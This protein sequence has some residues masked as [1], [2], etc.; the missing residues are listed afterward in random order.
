MDLPPPVVHTAECRALFVVHAVPASPQIWQ[1]PGQSLD[2]VGVNQC[3]P[4][5]TLLKDM[6][7][8]DRGAGSA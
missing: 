2:A 3:T 8:E 1:N 6:T 5:R 7:A 4:K